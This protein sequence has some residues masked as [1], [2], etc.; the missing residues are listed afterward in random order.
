MAAM[1][2]AQLI[3]PLLLSHSRQN[4]G[5]APRAAADGLVSAA[6]SARGSPS[7]GQQPTLQSRA[8]RYP[9]ASARRGTWPAASLRPLPP[10]LASPFSNTTARG[11]R[12]RRESA[13]AE[14]LHPLRPSPGQGFRLACDLA[15]TGGPCC[16]L[17]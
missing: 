1:K 14:R 17:C 2:S 6:I 4:G 5:S 12:S 10:A 16:W 11:L 9:E 15:A 3:K 8:A 7:P 13:A